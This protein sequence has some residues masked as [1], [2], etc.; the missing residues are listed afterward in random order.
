[1][2]HRME[3]PTTEF[4]TPSVSGTIRTY[5]ATL[6]SVMPWKV[7]LAL[8]LMV[9]LSL[10]EGIGLL[11][12]VP[13]LQLVGLDVQQGS[14]DGVA[15]FFLSAFTAIGMRP[16]LIAVLGLYVL[17]IGTHALLYRWQIILNVTLHYEFVASLR[18][19][20]YKAI[21]DTNWL[22]FS[23]SRSSDFIHVLTIEVERVGEATDQLLHLL[24]AA[25]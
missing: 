6:V 13:L 1:M 18:K 16:T 3:K 8:A 15:R 20:L 7:A 10:T 11:L 21:G 22:F 2:G 14:L 19:R 23:R 4:A 9:C 25:M 17:I 12:L 24:A 5:L